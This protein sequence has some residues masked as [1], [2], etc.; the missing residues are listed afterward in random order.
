MPGKRPK[1]FIL[2][3]LLSPKRGDQATASTLA[4][5]W[6]EI[7]DLERHLNSPSNSHNLEWAQMG[8]EESRSPHTMS[9]NNTIQAKGS[10]QKGTY[11]CPKSTSKLGHRSLFPGMHVNPPP[12]RPPQPT[13]M[14]NCSHH[15]LPNVFQCLPGAFTSSFVHLLECLQTFDC[16]AGG[17]GLAPPKEHHHQTPLK[18]A[19]WRE[20][21]WTQKKP[22]S[23]NCESGI[24]GISVTRVSR[25]VLVRLGF[26]KS[27][28][29]HFDPKS[30]SL[31]LHGD[32]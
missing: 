30:I 23:E 31:V 5:W 6:F 25:Q 14:G 12:S 26:R 13:A 21:T 10:Q 17:G 22:L 24:F 19:R 28:F 20:V 9:E 7:W 15:Q 4:L 32:R 27:F 1:T 16:R 29:H 8:S 3:H 2:G 11:F 18:A